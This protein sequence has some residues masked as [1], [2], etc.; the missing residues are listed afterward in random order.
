MT[1]LERAE[2][3]KQLLQD[4]VLRQAFEN[5][6]MHYVAAIEVSQ[7]T[8]VEAHHD[9]A[10]CLKSLIRVQNELKAFANEIAVDKAKR[11]SES[12]IEKTRE[13]LS[14]WR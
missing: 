6:R 12:F 8:D 2:R 9:M 13:R 11:Q 14:A 10:L 3:A 1:P 5:V 7:S 4:P